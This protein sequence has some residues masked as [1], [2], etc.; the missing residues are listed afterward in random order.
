MQGGTAH[1]AEQILHAIKGEARS[2]A[3][4]RLGELAFHMEK[5]AR[6]NNLAAV[7][8]ALPMLHTEFEQLQH[9]WNEAD[10]DSLFA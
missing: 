9:F 5:Y 6:Q 1:G 10:W 3:A 8:A 4:P 7:F 2:I